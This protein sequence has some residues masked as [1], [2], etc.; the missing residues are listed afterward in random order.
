M[1]N[2]FVILSLVTVFLNTAHADGGKFTFAQEGAPAPFTGTLFDPEATAKMLAQS[3]FLRDEYNLKLAYELSA[4]EWVY[5]LELDQM[6]ITLDTE[7]SKYESTL[8]LKDKEIEQLNKVISKK[9]G[10]SA[11]AWGIVGGLIAG[12]G[13]TAVIA[14]AATK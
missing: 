14:K 13:T 4:Q 10:S 11:V 3:K 8:N 6:Q 12:V 9:P 1:L 2:K 7:K 5:K